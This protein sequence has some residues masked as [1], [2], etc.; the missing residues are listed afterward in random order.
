MTRTAW[1]ISWVWVVDPEMYTGLIA[2]KTKK[3]TTTAKR[4]WGYARQFSSPWNLFQSSM[5][6]LRIWLM[7]PY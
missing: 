2:S 3:A 6:S 1:E 4:W 7:R 5:N